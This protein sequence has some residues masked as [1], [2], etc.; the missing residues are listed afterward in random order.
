M[1]RVSVEREVES[2]TAYLAR[3]LQPGRECE[4]PGLARESTWQ[5][6]MLDLRRQRQRNRPLSPLEEIRVAAV[7]NHDIRQE[8]RRLSDIGHRLFGRELIQQELENADRFTA[9][10]HGREQPSAAILVDHLDSLC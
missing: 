7:C 2:V 6:P 8:V 5:Q 1:E 9:A 3:R 4:L 10:G